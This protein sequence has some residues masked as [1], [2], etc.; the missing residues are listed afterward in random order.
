MSEGTEQSGHRKKAARPHGG[1]QHQPRARRTALHARSTLA[2][3]S[4]PRTAVRPRPPCPAGRPAP[5]AVASSVCSSKDHGSRKNTSEDGEALA[6]HAQSIS[7]PISRL[8]DP[9]PPCPAEGPAPFRRPPHQALPLLF[10]PALTMATLPPSPPC[11]CGG[12]S[13]QLRPSFP[14]TQRRGPCR[15][16]RP[17][18]AV[19]L[20]S[21]CLFCLL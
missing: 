11:G 6:F 10:V 7:A 12:C 19:R 21:R 2:P 18:S 13:K 17:V 9:S 4:P 8:L 5:S 15:T 16:P 1:G 3:H 14:T 20:T